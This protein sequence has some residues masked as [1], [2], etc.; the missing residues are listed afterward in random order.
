MGHVGLLCPLGGLTLRRFSVISTDKLLFLYIIA[1]LLL[2]LLS[3]LLLQ[4]H[5]VTIVMSCILYIPGPESQVLVTVQIL[6]GGDTPTL[7]NL[8]PTEARQKNNIQVQSNS[9]R[10]TVDL[11]PVKHSAL[12]PTPPPFSLRPWSRFLLIYPS[13]LLCAAATSTCSCPPF[14]FCPIARGCRRALKCALTYSTTSYHAGRVLHRGSQHVC[15]SLAVEVSLLPVS[16][17][18]LCCKL[19]LSPPTHRSARKA[20]GPIPRWCNCRS[21]F[22]SVSASVAAF[23]YSIEIRPPNLSLPLLELV[24]IFLIS[25]CLRGS[26]TS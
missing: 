26:P 14:S 20:A 17:L 23:N 24:T 10:C 13:I 2:L 12:T 1:S 15:G 21:Q 18:V 22:S 4:L 11:L 9:Q 6:Q 3:L 16:L 25:W 19:G 5:A 8:L 7:E